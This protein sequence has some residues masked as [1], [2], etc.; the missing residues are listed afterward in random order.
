VLLSGIELGLGH[1]ELKSY[2][3]IIENDFDAFLAFYR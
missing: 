3:V 2:L 1:S